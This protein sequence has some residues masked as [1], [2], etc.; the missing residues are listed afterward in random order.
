MREGAGRPRPEGGGELAAW[1]FM[2]VSGL[3]LL[4]LALGH[5]AIMH[6]IHGVE[7][8]DYAFVAGRFA[9]PFWRGYDLLMLI[10]AMGHGVNGIRTIIDDY[11]HEPARRRWVLGIVYTISAIFLVMGAGA[12]VLFEPKA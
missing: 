11:V 5:L 10:L 2:R 12:I 3:L 9:Q 7:A 8:I 6:L 1:V 4:F